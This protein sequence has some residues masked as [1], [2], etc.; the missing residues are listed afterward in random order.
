VYTPQRSGRVPL[1]TWDP[2]VHRDNRGRLSVRI[3]DMRVDN[4]MTW[5]VPARA[6]AGVTSPGSLRAGT[7]YLVT[8]A[9]TWQAVRGLTADA[10]CSRRTADP[11]WRRTRAL[12]PSKNGDDFD[13]LLDRQDF[14]WAP[15]TDTGDDC[16]AREHTYTYRYSQG[17][18]RPINL[19][20]SDAGP[21]ANNRGALTVRVRPYVAPPATVS[22]PAPA[23]QP[24]PQPQPE[25]VTPE[26]LTVYARSATPV[27]TERSYP[28]GT[29]LRLSVT[30]TYRYRDW[31]AA[32]AECNASSE[33]WGNHWAGRGDLTV[34]GVADKW[35]PADG[36]GDCDTQHRYSRELTVQQAGPVSFLVNENH[37]DSTGSLQVTVEEI[38]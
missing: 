28:V 11:V 1:R 7:D 23:P 5:K 3:V 35:W 14:G 19:R 15:K 26:T 29:R 20:V 10:E 12:D 25:P 8:V 30:G 9:G 38:R 32:D 27:R 4:R 22:E 13:V 33:G 31:V 34:N 17:E 2:T 37:P 16:D 18:N 36:A 21:Y 6:R 24:T